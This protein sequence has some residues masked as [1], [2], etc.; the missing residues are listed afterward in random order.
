MTP[1]DL[2]YSDQGAYEAGNVEIILPSK[3]ISIA[4][5]GNEHWLGQTHSAE[6]RA[7]RSVKAKA[8]WTPE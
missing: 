2:S 4:Y 8:R 6:T 7:L 1:D 3:N 5:I